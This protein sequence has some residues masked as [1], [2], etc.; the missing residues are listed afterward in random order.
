MIINDGPVVKNT[1]KVE[2]VTQWS[3]KLRTSTDHNFYLAN[4]LKAEGQQ[5]FNAAKALLN[6]YDRDSHVLYQNLK[7]SEK[8]YEE[9]LDLRTPK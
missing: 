5:K 7:K 4:L 8:Y 2:Q 1:N 9:Y 6:F 3:S